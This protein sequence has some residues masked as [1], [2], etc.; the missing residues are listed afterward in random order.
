MSKKTI[1]ITT[2]I[3]VFVIGI[4]I[5]IGN[6][7]SNKIEALEQNLE[8][9][10]GSIETLTLKNGELVSIRDSYILQID[11]LENRL[12]VS[13]KEVKDLQKKL[14]SQLAYI[15]TLK[16]ETKIDTLVTV[17]DSII[18]KTP[19]LIDVKF[20][21]NDDWISFNG[22]NKLTFSNNILADS[23]VDIYNLN[24]ITPITLGITEDLRL[25]A[26]SDNPY[27]TFTN[28]DGA[29]LKNS[30][31]YKKKSP[32]DFSLHV[33]FGLQY[34]LINKQFGIGPYGG[35]GI[36]YSF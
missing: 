34:N 13:T 11:E 29:I 2:I 12:D 24:I 35:G 26:T 28:M 20:K 8:A 25:F 32:W 31:F 6:Y 17:R 21:Y 18:Y 23:K 36:S 19:E 30:P 27:V 3:G 14:K 15:S 1:I 4:S 33:G 10:E 9:A 5:A 16:T 22:T 7:Y